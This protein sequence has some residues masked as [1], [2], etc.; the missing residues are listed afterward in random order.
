MKI[1]G[2]TGA[3]NVTTSGELELKG[4]TAKLEGSGQ[5]EVKASGVLHRPGPPSVKIEHART[6]GARCHQQRGSGDPTG[7]PGVIG[8]PG[9]PTVLIAGHAGGHRRHPA[10]LLVPAARGA[11]AVGDRAARLPDAC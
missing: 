3:V 5:T 7:H 9:V 6:G 8:P 10:H 2:G 1:D 11:P 4:T